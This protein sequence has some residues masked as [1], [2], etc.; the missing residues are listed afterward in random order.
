MTPASRPTIRD[1]A[2]EAGVSIATISK[3][4]NGREGVA[5]ETRQRVRAAADELGYTSR[6]G[7][8]SLR[9]VRT[10]VIGILVS[11]FDPYA[12]EVL[13]GIA[14]G[15]TGLPP[16]ELMAW[17]GTVGDAPLATGWESR[18]LQRLGGSLIDGAIIITPSIRD[19][20]LVDIPIVVV[21]PHE[22][23][24]RY[25]SVRVDDRAGARQAVAHLAGLGHRRIGF[26]GGRPDLESARERLAGYHEGM[27]AHGLP[28]DESLVTEGD[29]TWSGAVAPAERLLG[30]A[31]RPTAVFAASD[32]S[33]LCLIAAAEARGLRIPEDLSVIGFDDIPDAHS[34][35][36]SL[37]TVAQP[38]ARIGA[39]AV[40]MLSGLL[41]GSTPPR[42]HVRLEAQLRAGDTTSAPGS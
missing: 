23:G 6:I 5:E 41:R 26:I 16:L 15:A 38:L 25:P 4:M 22:G 2:R 19:D 11:G 12:T 42:R 10:G 21:D 33:A 32:M 17:A 39:T 7:T 27:A 31:D 1:V 24:Q 20:P 30:H 9:A 34:A 40:E 37:T 13:K 35:T 28:V 8:Q 14:R 36:R 29:Y 18:L 3:V